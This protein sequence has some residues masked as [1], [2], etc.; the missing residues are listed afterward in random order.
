[1]RFGRAAIL[2]LDEKPECA[3]RCGRVPCIVEAPSGLW[4]CIEC[5][6]VAAAA[7]AASSVPL[8]AQASRGEADRARA[9]IRG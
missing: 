8:L 4:W 3:G 1:M 6:R 2:G 7:G 5:R 9:E